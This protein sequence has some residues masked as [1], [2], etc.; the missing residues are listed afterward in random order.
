MLSRVERKGQRGQSFMTRPRRAS[1][2]QVKGF[3]LDPPD[4]T[5]PLLFEQE[6]DMIGVAPWERPVIHE[7][8]IQRQ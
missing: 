7:V 2:Y 3:G 5:E 1:E 6:S 4:N 8:G